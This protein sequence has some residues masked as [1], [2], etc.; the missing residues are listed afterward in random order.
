MKTELTTDTCPCGSGTPY[1]NCCGPFH[2][3]EAQAPT[4]EKL[5]RSRYSAFV[6]KEYDY[7]EETLDPQTALDF[8]HEGNRAWAERMDLNKLEILRSEENGNKAVVEFKAYHRE[9]G[10]ERIHHE[11]SKFRKQAG[12]WYFREGKVYKS[13]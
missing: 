6:K 5:M 10:E 11:V 8:D 2:T 13:V 4:A 7:L 12:V 3:G 1:Q 9:D